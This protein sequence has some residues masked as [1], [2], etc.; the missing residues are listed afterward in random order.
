TASFS[1]VPQK[2]IP[3]YGSNFSFI[4]LCPESSD[5][6]QAR[7]IY[8]S[9]VTRPH[10]RINCRSI[11]F[12][13]QPFH[14]WQKVR[15]SSTP[16]HTIIHH[17]PPA[18]Q[19]PCSSLATG[20]DTRVVRPAQ[21]SPLEPSIPIHFLQLNSSFSSL[22]FDHLSSS[23]YPTVGPPV[24]DLPRLVVLCNLLSVF[25]ALEPRLHDSLTTLLN[26]HLSP[27]F[28]SHL[29]AFQ[30]NSRL[31]PPPTYLSL[32]FNSQPSGIQLLVAARQRSGHPVSISHRPFQ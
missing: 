28:V 18:E 4:S 1:H 23:C 29:T 12:A 26:S 19:P 10:G 32:R 21:P 22:M 5:I 15:R 13:T 7:A 14:Y 11:P 20:E 17:S 24:Y 8:R 25:L 30:L 16:R 2:W 9:C 27:R 31:I 3:R 6:Q